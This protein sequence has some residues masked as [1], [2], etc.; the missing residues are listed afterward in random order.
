MVLSKS[1]LESWVCRELNK[2]G[3]K[4]VA[5]AVVNSAVGQADNA[6]SGSEPPRPMSTSPSPPPVQDLIRGPAPA[7]FGPKAAG[8]ATRL[9]PT[10][11]MHI[12]CAHGL[13]NPA[14]SAN[15][16]RVSK[17]GWKSMPLSL[18][19]RQLAGGMGQ[20]KEMRH[21]RGGHRI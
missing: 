14:E 12:T 18:D 19:L 3:A 8:S 10:T 1:D 13:L 9:T 6:A 17:V 15:M 16:K 11:G 7:P 21:G 5:P 2:G 20:H 4:P